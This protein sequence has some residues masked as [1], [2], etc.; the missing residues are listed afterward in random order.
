MAQTSTMS[1]VEIGL[2][3]LAKYIWATFLWHYVVGPAFHLPTNMSDSALI[4]FIF[5]AN[6][7]V[8]AFLFRRVFSKIEK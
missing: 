7:A 5:M 6:G 3:T 8:I 2:G 4:T 1:V